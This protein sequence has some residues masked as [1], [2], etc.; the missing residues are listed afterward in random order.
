MN[1]FPAEQASDLLAQVFPPGPSSTFTELQI[2]AG[3]L[4]GRRQMHASGH[5]SFVV[6]SLIWAM[7]IILLWVLDEALPAFVM[8]GGLCVLAIILMTHVC[9][10]EKRLQF[11]PQCGVLC[12]H[13]HWRTFPT[14][15]GGCDR[16]LRPDQ[17]VGPR[18]GVLEMRTRQQ[19]ARSEPIV[20]LVNLVLLLAIREQADE[21]CFGPQEGEHL[22][23]TCKIGGQVEDFVPPA[24]DLAPPIGKYVK[25]LAGLNPHAEGKCQ[26]GAVLVQLPESALQMNVLIEPSAHGEKILLRFV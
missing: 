19:V 1:R 22:R 25:A 7:G 20:Q 9:W 24:S 14:W 5:I 8:G 23:L 11:C 6:F 3:P 10:V 26:Q 17:L 12:G 16:L 21:V 13:P 2:D 18:P 15:C 4:T